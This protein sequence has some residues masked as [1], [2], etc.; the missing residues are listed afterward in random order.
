MACSSSQ[1]PGLSVLRG[2]TLTDLQLRQTGREA[3]KGL[4]QAT[5]H[6][7]PQTGCHRPGR[8]SGRGKDGGGLRVGETD[9]E[10]RQ[11]A[12]TEGKPRSVGDDIDN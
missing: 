11:G 5:S 9:W 4:Q 6:Q 3:E 12:A 1:Q 10:V 7:V 2:G 8:N